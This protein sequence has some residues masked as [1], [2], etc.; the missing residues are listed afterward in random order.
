MNEKLEKIYKDG[1]EN[2]D[3]LLDFDNTITTNVFNGKPVDAAFS[4]F[5]NS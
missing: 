2:L 3:C 5:F 1:C 4:M